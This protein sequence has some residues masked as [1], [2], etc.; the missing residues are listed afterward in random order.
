MP[1]DALGSVLLPALCLYLGSPAALGGE[2]YNEQI[3]SWRRQR[4]A[5]LKAEDGWLTVSGL[6]WLRPG[7][8]RIGSDPSNDILLPTHAP[9]SV[10]TLTLR[11]G[12]S[13]SR[14]RPA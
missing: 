7:E 4:E 10:G 11:E 3:E 13:T 9:A 12:T 8:T 6:F 1:R 2:T 5:G 14:P